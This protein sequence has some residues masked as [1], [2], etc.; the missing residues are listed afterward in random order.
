MYPPPL[1][2]TGSC[3]HRFLG[4]DL[5]GFSWRDRHFFAVI[6]KRSH[7]FRF[8][9]PAQAVRRNNGCRRAE[10]EYPGSQFKLAANVHFHRDAATTDLPH[11]LRGMPYA[12]TYVFGN[13]RIEDD[14]HI[15]RLFLYHS[16]CRFEIGLNRKILRFIERLTRFFDA[17]DTLDGERADLF[18]LF[19]ECE[20]VQPPTE[21]HQAIGMDRVRFLLLAMHR[22][23][24]HLHFHFFAD[25]IHHRPNRSF[26]MLQ[27]LWRVRTNTDHVV[28]AVEKLDITLGERALD[29]FEGGSD[30]VGK[31]WRRKIH[32]QLFAE[33]HRGSF[34]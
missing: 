16:E 31:R 14:L 10:T 6:L 13:V 8:H 2:S 11:L 21:V 1:S 9:S 7:Q 29:F 25:G 18:V 22:V 20:Q 28:E 33:I 34:R 19:N 26:S 17:F 4:F 3:C 23:I 15:K 12:G 32:H 27:V 5:L 24:L 30:I